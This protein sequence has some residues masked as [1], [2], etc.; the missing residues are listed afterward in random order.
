MKIA[1]FLTATRLPGLAAGLVAGLLCGTAT[2]AQSTGAPWAHDTATIG[3][4]MANPAAN[5]ILVK[6]FPDITK[7]PPEARDFTLAEV[8][9]FAP[10][11]YTAAK[12]ATLGVPAEDVVKHY[13]ENE[14]FGELSM[15]ILERK[16]REFLRDKAKITDKAVEGA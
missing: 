15:G 16:V 9:Q 13:R 7:A 11:L 8:R 4:L 5:A 14:L 3:E 1:S 2:F 10:Q 12:L 6:N